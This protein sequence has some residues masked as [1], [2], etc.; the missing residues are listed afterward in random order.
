MTI[1]SVFVYDYERVNGTVDV[2][3]TTCVHLHRFRDRVLFW[4]VWR[5]SCDLTGW[6]LESFLDGAVPKAKRC[7][8]CK[9]LE[10][11][12]ER[13]DD[14]A[15]SPIPRATSLADWTDYQERAG[16]R[17]AVVNGAVTRPTSGYD[18]NRTR[19]LGTEPG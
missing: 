17:L 15:N 10:R 8:E 19:K 9:H 11:T 7:S 4:T 18:P 5:H 1:S 16:R 6:Q 3:R 14:V 12:C 2:C 13:F